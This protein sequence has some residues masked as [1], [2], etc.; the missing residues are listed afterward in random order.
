MASLPDGA[1]AAW[2]IGYAQVHGAIT[3]ELVGRIPSQLQPA[4]LFDLQMA[5]ISG[6]LHAPPPPW[7]S[8]RRGVSTR[9]LAILADLGPTPEMRRRRR[10][11]PETRARRRL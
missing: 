10:R 11:A 6:S 9:R 3:L 4:P 2:L 1:L 8:N 7:K 5:H